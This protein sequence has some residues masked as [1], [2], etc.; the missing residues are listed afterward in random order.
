MVTAVRPIVDDLIEAWNSHD[1]DDVVQFFSDDYEGI[2]VGLSSPQ[3]GQDGIRE[4][5]SRYLTAFPDMRI[6][7]DET[8]IQGDRVAMVWTF[9]GTHLGKWSNIPPTN[10]SVVMRGVTVLGI[11]DGRIVSGLYVWDFAGLL[12]SL[13][14]L[15]DL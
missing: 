13:R 7:L 12:R 9:R 14:L 11:E 3:R 4:S 5:I 10:R 8:V 1:I 15:P 6:A 2:D